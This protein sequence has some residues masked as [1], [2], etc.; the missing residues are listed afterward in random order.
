MPR[1]SRLPQA[2]VVAL[3]C[4]G[5]LA[6]LPAW[7]AAPAAGERLSAWLLR[8][9]GPQADTTALH[10]RNTSEQLPQLQLRQ[11]VLAAIESSPASAL[12]GAQRQTL[13]DWVAR[14]P[15][16]GRLTLA[17]H[18]PR[19][20]EVMP[21]ADP[22][23]GSADEFVRFARPTQVLVVNEAGLPCLVEH[24]AGA[25]VRDYLRACASALAEPGEVDWAW[26]AQPDGRVQSMGVAAWNQTPQHP[27]GPGAWIWAPSRDASIARALSDNLAR[28][29]ATQ[30]PPEAHP[31][32]AGAA[33]Q[34]GPVLAARRS[35]PIGPTFTSN[36]WGELGFLQTPSA[37]MAG[38]G[39]VRSTFSNV[40]PYNRLTVKLQPLDWFEFGFRYTD[41]V[42]RLYGPLAGRQS[43]KDKSVDVKLRLRAEDARWP[44]VA[45]GLRD[46]G[47]TGL[48]ASEY[49]VASKR[50]GNWDAS[51]GLGW[52]NMGSRGN[53]ANP[54]R[55]LGSRFERRAVAD[56]GLGGDANFDKI[57]TG[58]AALFGGLQWSS[59]TSPWVLM[60][61]LDGNSY[62][63]EPLNNPQP[64]DSP[65][66]FGLVYRY[67]PTLAFTLSWQRGN[68]LAFGL[69]LQ[70]R[71]DQ[72]H[73]PKLLDPALPPLRTQAP[74]A[75][76]AAG[77]A[78]VAGEINRHTGWEVQSVRQVHAEA[79]IAAEVDQALH[80][81]QRVESVTRL[82]H[83]LAPA[84]IRSFRLQ[85]TRRALPLSEL[86]I[87]RH[88]W[89]LQQAHALPPSQALVAQRQ[90]GLAQAP[91]PVGPPH[92]QAEPATWR[93]QWSP[94]FS[95]IIG[96]PD[97]FVLYELGAAASAEWRPAPGTWLAGVASLRLLDNYESFDF[98]GRSD[99]PRV[100]TFLR[101]YVISSRLT[102]PRLHLTHA[103]HLGGNHYASAYAGLLEPMFG[104]VGAEWLYRPFGRSWAFGVDLNHVQQRGFR[105]D[106]SF[107]DYR[108]TTG[109]AT[110]HWDTGWNDVHAKVQ[111]GRYLAGDEGLTL[112]LSRT[113]RNGTAI[114][115]WATFTNVPFEAFG[116][117]SF[118]KGIYV[119]IP[120]DAMLP[121][122]SP[123]IADLRWTPLTRDGGARLNRPS[124]LFDLTQAR[125]ARALYW[126]AAAPAQRR[127]AE[128]TSQ[129]LQVPPALPFDDPAGS[130]GR[131]LDQISQV[132]AATWLTAG[133]AL[134]GSAL[135]DA[136]AD[137]WAARRQGGDW[138]RFGN[139]ASAAPY[140]LAAGSALLASGVAGPAAAG[141][142]Q[143]SLLAG[144]YALGA[145]VAV[146]TLAGRSRPREGQGSAQFSGPGAGSLR[147]SLPSNHTALAFALAT[148]FARQHD[149]PWLYGV[150]AAT[151]LAR[152]QQREHWLSDT[153]GGALL[154]YGI[155][156]LLSMQQ[157]ANPSGPRIRVTGQSIQADWRF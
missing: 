154:G 108:V 45:I 133:S 84:E 25:L 123:T 31:L 104:G 85:L 1:S 6:G 61:E 141:T 115:A 74:A 13:A 82:L 148:P 54:L 110:L 59:P 102:I 65:L 124:T 117:G 27:P 101:E 15:L 58:P 91:P 151:A 103:R 23:R 156:A 93:L 44:E 20:L 88:E 33:V 81:E 60:A 99:L 100:R 134:L 52:G 127:S 56:V 77:W 55:L 130:A 78:G 29:L 8:T 150:A 144:A 119:R 17:T 24:V 152:V 21:E 94:T 70:G 89:L 12:S 145:S 42:N 137:G 10:W 114:G 4:G 76:P 98:T 68:R 120:F 143:T 112:D 107:R 50:W 22:V 116:E 7:A 142:A 126:R 34:P 67:S 46:L 66:N 62:Q 125:G 71:L 87:D 49:L 155:G 86:H 5:A 69:S 111:A 28:L 38:A 53:V 128:R 83:A 129:V 48:F 96:G 106:F 51:L 153:V 118:D 149:M 95:Q 109:H 147:S 30:A 132:P 40:Y 73:S 43:Y 2:W 26:V 35:E 90:H 92:W 97:G 75:L 131:L 72:L 37:R 3:L 18:D 47:G 36:D 157:E 146:R 39:T 80:L 105:Q 32:L 14:L 11:A 140:L 16:T 135:L 79:I 136:S 121:L 138:D 63:A 9:Y 113:F 19:A 64:V 41:I 57:F 139:V 122:S